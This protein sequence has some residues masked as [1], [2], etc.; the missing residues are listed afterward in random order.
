MARMTLSS[1]VLAIVGVAIFTLAVQASSDSFHGR[2]SLTVNGPLTESPIPFDWLEVPSEPVTRIVADTQFDQ[3][4]IVDCRIFD[5]VKQLRRSTIQQGES[6]RIP[7][8]RNFLEG[9]HPELAK[10]R[11]SSSVWLLGLDQVESIT[12]SDLIKWEAIGVQNWFRSWRAASEFVN[13]ISIVCN[14]SLTD[15]KDYLIRL[16][17][18]HRQ[19]TLD[20]VDKQNAM[21]DSSFQFQRIRGDWVRKVKNQNLETVETIM[22]MK[23]IAKLRSNLILISFPA[24]KKIETVVRPAPPQRFTIPTDGLDD[25]YWQY[26]GDCDYW[27]VNFAQSEK[28]DSL[29]SKAP[30]NFV[31]L[32]PSTETEQWAGW[33]QVGGMVESL[34]DDLENTL[35]RVKVAMHQA[36]L[37]SQSRFDF[38]AWADQLEFMIVEY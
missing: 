24:E 17:Q 8:V 20:L 14:R 10:H 12:P 5:R 31:T 28:S 23:R 34:V 37:Q 25:S 30:L 27:K 35:D 18:T 6:W 38:S 29:A 36:V 13:D 4:G 9:T 7:H 22:P 11:T 19:R 21:A 26:Y 3:L 33:A 2:D 15:A 1:N 32:D 16:S